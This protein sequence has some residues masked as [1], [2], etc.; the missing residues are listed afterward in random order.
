MIVKGLILCAIAGFVVY[1]LIC[2]CAELMAACLK[3]EDDDDS[4]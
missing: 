3:D 2:A 4:R 1:M